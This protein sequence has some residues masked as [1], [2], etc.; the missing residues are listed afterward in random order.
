MNYDGDMPVRDYWRRV[1]NY[2]KNNYVTLLRWLAAETIL[3]GLAFGVKCDKS[4]QLK[5]QPKKSL[6]TII[7]KN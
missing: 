2:I 5:R 3:T 6:T 7:N 1:R 4:R